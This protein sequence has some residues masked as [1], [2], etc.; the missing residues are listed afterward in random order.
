MWWIRAVVGDTIIEDEREAYM[1]KYL[2][3][4]PFQETFNARSGGAIARWVSEIYSRITAPGVA[5]C[6][7]TLNDGSDYKAVNVLSR[8]NNLVR[9]LRNIPIARRLLHFYYCFIYF[10]EIRSV[11]SIEIHNSFQYIRALRFLGYRNKIILHMH[12]DYLYDLDINSL[13]FIYKNVHQVILCSHFL[14]KRLL[15]KCSLFRDKISVIKNGYDP[16][17]FYPI[18]GMKDINCLGYVARVDENKGLS[19]LL[20]VYQLL[21]L[22][23]PQLVLYVI[24]G[25]TLDYAGLTDYEKKCFKKIKYVNNELGG[26]IEWLGRMHGE[27]LTKYYNKFGIFCSLPRQNEAFGMTFVE[28]Q[29]CGTLVLGSDIGGVSEAILQ[30][31]LVLN[32]ESTPEMV[33]YKVQSLLQR[34]KIT[35]NLGI[36]YS[37]GLEAEYSW[38]VLSDQQQ[39]FMR[40]NDYL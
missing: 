26:T 2:V 32:R 24:G 13:T 36:E 39:R 11:Q 14:E 8:Q 5:I 34:L 25:S 10:S 30:E 15:S 16:D 40:E 27:S 31:G 38:S 17:V 9:I 35:P 19:F 28:A 29:A 20:E 21:L 1:A 37:K 33:S 12:N 6:A 18:P 23:N 3:M 4:L 22:A 7:I